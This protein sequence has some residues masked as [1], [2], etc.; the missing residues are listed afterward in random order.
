MFQRPGAVLHQV[1][2]ITVQAAANGRTCLVHL[3]PAQH[4]NGFAARQFFGLLVI[5][6]VQQLNQGTLGGL[7]REIDQVRHRH[8]VVT[9][10]FQL[11]QRQRE[12]AQS[13]L[14]G[15]ALMDVVEAA[16]ENNPG[17]I[18]RPS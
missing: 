4:F 13:F 8:V 2:V 12:N 18:A 10:G 3:Q 1:G 11:I 7:A 9:G 16:H 6:I 17:G 14:V 5:R 15:Q